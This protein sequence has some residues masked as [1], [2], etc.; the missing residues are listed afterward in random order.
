MTE[1]IVLKG[2]TNGLRL[3]MNPDI[4]IEQLL[5]SMC[6]KF[7]ESKRFSGA[8]LAIALEGSSFS[9]TRWKQ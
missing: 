7:A 4:P 1:D 5:T 3:I 9:T 2:Y 6:H 8:K